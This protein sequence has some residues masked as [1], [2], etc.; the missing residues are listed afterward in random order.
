[1]RIAV[2]Q[3]VC[4]NYRVPLFQRL[5]SDESITFQLYIGD[6]VPES[7]VK[8]ASNLE[9]IK[10]TRL[11]SRFIK[12]RG[13]FFPIHTDL[14]KNIKKFNPDVILCEGESNFF[15]Y[16]Q[17]I[18][19]KLILNRQCKLIHWC[20]IALPGENDSGKPII[21]N[22]KKFFRRFF[23]GFLLYST[24]SKKRLLEL[25]DVPENKMY[26]ATNVG[27]VEKML[28]MYSKYKYTQIE[29][30]EILELPNKFTVLY[31]G[32]LD[33]NK[34]PEI[35]IELA[36]LTKFKE[37]NFIIAGEG[38]MYDQL[39]KMSEDYNLKNIWITGRISSKL[40]DYLKASDVLVLPGRGG[41]V[42]SEALAFALPVIIHE[43]DGT[44]YDLI[45]NGLSGYIL[46]SGSIDSFDN[47]L[48]KLSSMDNHR[49][50]KMGK[51]GQELV[52]KR[53]NTESMI[54]QILYALNN[55]NN[56]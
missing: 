10:Y 47:C 21:A 45:I 19:Y 4:T 15:G 25:G 16:L 46:S 54:N 38:P 37:F 12:I 23:D 34:R 1:M 18:F 42:I 50:K 17:A 7:K 43:G 35:I 27:N 32:S 8:N 30:R 6:D 20:F 13:H 31:L 11:K 52:S 40:Y 55:V 39:I 53:F 24:Y 51:Y 26:V 9:G 29:I 14:L 48:S 56:N 41:I 2:L 44:E 49:R 33:K 5:S 3:R 22:V 36:K 28:K